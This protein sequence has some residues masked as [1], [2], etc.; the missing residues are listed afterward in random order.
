MDKRELAGNLFR[1][2]E[3]EARLKSERVYGQSPAETVA[4]EVGRKVRKIM[5]DSDGKPPEH[6]PLSSDIKDVRK[7]L[8]QAAKEFM[9]LDKPARQK[10]KQLPPAE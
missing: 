8:K 1:L 6:I 3:T 5:I 2:T 9:Q 10:K 4:F 7:N